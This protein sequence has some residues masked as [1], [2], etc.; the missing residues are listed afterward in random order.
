MK[1]RGGAG[2]Q[3][4]DRDRLYLLPP[5]GP[6][7]MG[8]P[9]LQPQRGLPTLTHTYLCLASWPRGW[10]RECPRPM[11]S[12]PGGTVRASPRPI[13]RLGRGKEERL[14]T[15]CLLSVNAFICQS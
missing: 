11:G 5:P 10:H 8:E 2:E 6:F 15:T 14:T 3:A 7:S 9:G 12:E 13:S 4:R 1:G